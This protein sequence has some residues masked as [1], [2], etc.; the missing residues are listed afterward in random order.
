MLDVGYAAASVVNHFFRTTH[1]Q[2]HFQCLV[3]VRLLRTVNLTKNSAHQHLLVTSSVHRESYVYCI[4]DSENQT[5]LNKVMI[6]N[7]VPLLK[8]TRVIATLGLKCING[9]IVWVCS[10]YMIT[11]ASCWVASEQM[12]WMKLICSDI[13]HQIVYGR[14]VGARF[15]CPVRLTSSERTRIIIQ[16][17]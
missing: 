13:L 6:N 14:P 15:V 9:N 10:L 17:M 2:Q 1:L 12:F 8:Y 16:C 4:T 11:R 7:K 3:L 5:I